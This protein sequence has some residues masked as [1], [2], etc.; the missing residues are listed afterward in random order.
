M[1]IGTFPV[2][3][4]NSPRAIYFHGAGEHWYLFK[5][6]GEQVHSLGD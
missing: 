1:S 2:Q 3:A 4:Q 5:G 6:A